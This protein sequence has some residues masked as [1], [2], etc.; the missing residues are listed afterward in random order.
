MSACAGTRV[1]V[2]GIGNPDRGDDGL[3]PAVTHLLRDRA[4]PG[5]R[6][7]ER[8]GDLLAL[9]DEW[10]GVAT[11][12]IVD[13]AAPTKC[14]G[15]VQRL[16]LTGAPLPVGLTVGSTHALGV[17]EAVEL[18]RILGRL[19]R[20]LVA[21]L[22][23]GERFDTGPPLSPAVR[24]AVEEVARRIA[25]ELPAFLSVRNQEGDGWAT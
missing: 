6:V 1:L 23:E 11:V 12:V 25:L 17:A 7:I 2:V 19:P 9:I 13:A 5:V 18:A 21:Y 20:R 4:P 14:P 24:K 16:D 22:V 8:N 15:Q 3:G 10:E